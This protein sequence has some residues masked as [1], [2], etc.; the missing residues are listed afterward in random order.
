MAERADE[1]IMASTVLLF[2]Y[3]TL[4]N[5]TVQISNFGRELKGREDALAGYVLGKVP[6]VDPDVIASSGESHYANVEPSSNPADVVSGTVFEITEQE[7]AIADKYEETAQC[8]R[9]SVT[10]QSGDPAWVYARA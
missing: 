6:I 8:R 5:K 1:R 7:L 3:G 10:L 9:I 4:Q 2:S